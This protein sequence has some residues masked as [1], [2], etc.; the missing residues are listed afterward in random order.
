MTDTSHRE[1]LITKEFLA[2]NAI[3]FLTYC[4][5]AVFFQFHEYLGTLPIARDSFGLLIALFALTAVLIRPVISPFLT[6]WNARKWIAISSFLVVVS[7]GLYDVADGFWSMAAVRLFHGAVHTV[8]A[9]AVLSRMVGCIPRERSGQAFGLI[10]VIVLLPYAVIPPILEPLST[11]L[12]GFR[13]VLEISALAM[14]LVFPLLLVM[15]RKSVC[16]SDPEGKRIGLRE[17]VENLKDYRILIMFAVALVVWTAFTPVFYFLKGYGDK[18]GIQNPGWFF[19]LSTVTEIL[20]RLMAAPVFDKLNKPKL[21]TGSL[22]WLALGYFALANVRG[23]GFFYALGLFLGLGWGIVMPLLSSLTFDLSEPRFRAMNSNFTMQMFQAGFFVGPVFGDIILIHGDYSLLY[24]GCG[25]L[26][27]LGV[28]A[29]LVLCSTKP[30]EK[31][32]R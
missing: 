12:G 30:S 11:L 20:V 4:N 21:M 32:S 13:H 3:M 1:P 14:L 9:T 26:L 29:G 2:L 22:I 5:I 7:L 25:G 18:I 23:D 27:V 28:V 24:Y 6:P 10:F 19:T 31:T 16:Q 17:M 8:L 15:D